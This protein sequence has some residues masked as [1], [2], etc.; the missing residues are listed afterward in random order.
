MGV[1]TV[2][3]QESGETT[4][5]PIRP[6]H[7]AFRPGEKESRHGSGCAVARRWPEKADGPTTRFAG[8]RV[9]Y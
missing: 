6:V 8:L 4:M 2:D 1:T 9:F 7:S 3:G 5:A